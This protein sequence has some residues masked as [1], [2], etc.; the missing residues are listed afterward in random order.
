MPRP[1]SSTNRKG[2]TMNLL[3]TAEINVLADELL[4][5]AA[6]PTAV[7]DTAAI[8][9]RTAHLDA[10]EAALDAAEAFMEAGDLT[11]SSAQRAIARVHLA[12]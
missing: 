4:A 3:T 7:V 12:A 2:H 11:A 10:A 5:I 1:T 6:R 8:A 9:A